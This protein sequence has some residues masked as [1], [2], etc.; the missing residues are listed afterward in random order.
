M[1]LGIIFVKKKKKKN[2][3]SASI[4]LT[5]VDKHNSSGLP[6]R[7]VCESHESDSPRTPSPGWSF[8][9]PKEYWDERI[10]NSEPILGPTGGD[11]DML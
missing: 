2:L 1:T 4:C 10:I 9:S 3:H 7:D 5:N 11:E 6:S 8:K